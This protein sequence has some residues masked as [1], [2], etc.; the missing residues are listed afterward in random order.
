M[1]QSVKVSTNAAKSSGGGLGFITVIN[2]VLA[3]LIN[4]NIGT[5]KLQAFFYQNGFGRWYYECL[6]GWSCIPFIILFPTCV[7]LAIAAVVG[8]IV[9]LAYFIGD[10]L[11]DIP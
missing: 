3:V 11:S 1:N 8:A 6:E 10:K 2:I 4:L 7:A 5:E 9:F